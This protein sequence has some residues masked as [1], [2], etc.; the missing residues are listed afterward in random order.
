MRPLPSGLPVV[1]LCVVAC[2]VPP[3]ELL[4][5]HSVALLQLAD[6]L[7]GS[8]EPGG[9]ESE[10]VAQSRFHHRLKRSC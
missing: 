5:A 6:P 7:L 1:A 3:E 10:L 4:S 8:A 9:D 2:L